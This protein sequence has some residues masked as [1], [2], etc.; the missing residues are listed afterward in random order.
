MNN[1]TEFRVPTMLTIDE[2]AAFFREK[3]PNTRITKFRIRKLVLSN[4]IP[5]VK[6]GNRYLINLEMFIE[7]LNNYSYVNSYTPENKYG[8]QKIDEAR[9]R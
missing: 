1:I 2:T 9:G 8:I 3:H 4:Q 5:F 7:F 6:A